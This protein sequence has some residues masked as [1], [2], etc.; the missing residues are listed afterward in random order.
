MRNLILSTVFGLIALP[1]AAGSIQG[2]WAGQPEHCTGTYP[3]TKVKISGSRIS[4]MDSSCTLENPTALRGMPEAK[5]YD[6]T[7]SGEGETWS[8]RVLIGNDGDDLMIYSR[9]YVSTYKS[10]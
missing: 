5:L 1:V 7:C 6:K 8:E 2:T 9:G 4:F 10:C 3:E